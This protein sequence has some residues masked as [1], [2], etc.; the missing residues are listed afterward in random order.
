MPRV[1]TI[2]DDAV[3][4]GEIVAELQSRGN[5][6]DW[7]DNGREGLARASSGDYDVIT[8]DRMLPGLDGLALVTSLRNAGVQTPVLMISA[9]SD[10]DER[11]RGLRAGGDD[12][13]TKP[14]APDEMA[15][16]ID[17]LLRRGQPAARTTVLSVG[18]LRLDLIERSARRGDVELDLLP[19]EFRLLEF[20][21]RNSGQV[22][23]RTMIFERVW[24]YHFDPGTNV[25][26]VHI[27]RL[28]RKVDPPGLPAM[29]VTV[30]GSGYLLGMP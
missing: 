30:R 15:A 14:L 24:G 20:L 11:V 13:L 12:Y 19:I 3:V 1:L 10:V 8:L 7:V 4:A 29:I 17:V 2:E 22:L 25:I 5:Q 21:V 27:G 23:T 18:D 28:R 9:L 6:V 16:R 26:D